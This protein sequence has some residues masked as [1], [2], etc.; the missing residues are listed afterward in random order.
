MNF[1]KPKE[2]PATGA[3]PPSPPHLLL[4]QAFASFQTHFS[5][6]FHN[7]QTNPPLQNTLFAKISN[8]NN[9]LPGKFTASSS[10]NSNNYVP[11]Y[12]LGNV[13]REF[14]LLS[15]AG[16]SLGLFCF[17]KADAEALLKQMNSADPSTSTG[18]QVVPVALS[19]LV[20]HKV[21]G[22]ALRF[23]PEVSQI[24]NALNCM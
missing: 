17:S 20:Q 7:L 24:R 18:S 2:P 15:G 14:V 12:A 3:P 23:V 21:D 10:N 19:K 22:V 13:D 4:N 6:F 11:L 8:E 9:P 1:F 5:N 16:K